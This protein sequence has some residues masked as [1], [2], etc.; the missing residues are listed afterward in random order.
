MLTISDGILL[1]IITFIFAAGGFYW[2]TRINF[3]SF[4][5][6]LVS[7]SKENLAAR[8]EQIEEFKEIKEEFKEIKELLMEQGKTQAVAENEIKHL[9]D[10]IRHMRFYKGHDNN[11]QP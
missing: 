9:K 5:K 2:S 7:M 4:Q 6:E 11:A 3:K 1:S 8:A 10:D